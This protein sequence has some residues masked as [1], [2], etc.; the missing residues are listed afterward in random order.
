MVKKKYNDFIQEGIFKDGYLS[1]G[2]VSIDGHILFG[3]FYKD[4]LIDG[5]IFYPDG[6]FR[7]CNI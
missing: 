5:K 1:I 2:K 7:D 6:S 3:K 4:N